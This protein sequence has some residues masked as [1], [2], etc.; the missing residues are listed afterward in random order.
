MIKYF[1][2]NGRLFIIYMM[3]ESFIK[4][5]EK[6]ITANNLFVICRRFL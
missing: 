1:I 3:D 2:G 4:D 6:E 5:D